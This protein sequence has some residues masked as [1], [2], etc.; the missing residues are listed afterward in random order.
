[1]HIRNGRVMVP[2]YAARIEDLGP[3]D[4]MVIECVA[5]PNV[6]LLSGAYLLKLGLPPY[7]KLLELKRHTRC[8]GCGLR[9]R[10]VISI[11]WGKEVA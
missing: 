9:G 6:G 10:G 7:S 4:F 5:C 1:M 2:L 8:R 3:V 11:R